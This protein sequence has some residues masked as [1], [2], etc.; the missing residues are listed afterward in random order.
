LCSLFVPFVSRRRCHYVV[1]VPVVPRACMQVVVNTAADS[2]L[3]AD[4]AALSAFQ[5]FE[6][7]RN[8]LVAAQEIGLPCFEASDLEQVSVETSGW[9]ITSGFACSFSNLSPHPCF[10]HTLSRV[11]CLTCLFAFLG[12]GREE[13]Q[14][15]ELRPR[16]EVV[17]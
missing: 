10:L 14:G 16:T 1:T 4:G 13:R 9:G 3:Q 2:V 6:N 7:V 12:A 17:R 5:Y 15:G 8:F 11:A